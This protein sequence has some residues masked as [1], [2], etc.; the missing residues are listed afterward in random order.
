MSVNAAVGSRVFAFLQEIF[1]NEGDKFFYIPLTMGCIFGKI[2]E[3]LNYAGKVW[4]GSMVLQV[5]NNDFSF[6]RRKILW[7]NR[8][9]LVAIP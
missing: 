1:L 2:Y 7:Q 3:K 9:L 8:D 5:K 6:F 4:R